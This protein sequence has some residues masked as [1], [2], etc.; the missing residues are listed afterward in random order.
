MS[1]KRGRKP[2]ELD[3]PAPGVTN[4][5]NG[6]LRQKIELRAYFRYCERGCRPGHEVEDWVAA[7]QEVLAKR[8]ADAAN[9][10]R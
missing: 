3:G 2:Q 4:Q 1:H 5:D 7:E 10:A 9:T 6:E 8:P